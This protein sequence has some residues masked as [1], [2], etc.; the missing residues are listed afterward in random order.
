MKG[1]IEKTILS[2]KDN[3]TPGP[4]SICSEIHR[5]IFRSNLEF[6]DVL[7]QLFNDIYDTALEFALESFLKTGCIQYL[8]PNVR[9][10]V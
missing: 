7:K 2:L 5:I 1:E 10:Q 9:K 6:L 3:Q 4:D 8:S